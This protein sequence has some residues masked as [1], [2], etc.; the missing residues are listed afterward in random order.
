MS[1]D[2]NDIDA[3]EQI[4]E[5]L[6]GET[7]EV[8]L[9]TGNSGPDELNIEPLAVEVEPVG[10]VVTAGPSTSQAFSEDNCL[11]EACKLDKCF[12]SF[13]GHPLAKPASQ[14]ALVSQYCVVSTSLPFFI[15]KCTAR[16]LLRRQQK[17]T[18]YDHILEDHHSDSDTKQEKNGSDEPNF[19]NNEEHGQPMHK[20]L[21]R[22]VGKRKNR[23][24]L[25]NM[26]KGYETNNEN[27]IK[28]RQ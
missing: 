21:K 23:Q 17:E 18:A 13:N 4:F 2:G 25:R 15:R 9:Q 10:P 16:F 28:V 19:K 8:N 3:L 26:G 12:L 14:A 7:E 27:T 6:E 20:I 22:N 24:V 11:S 1:D 5:D